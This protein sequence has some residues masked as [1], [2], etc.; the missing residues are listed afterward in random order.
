MTGFLKRDAALLRTNLKFYLVF[1]LGFAVLSVFTDFSASFISL[2]LVVFAASSIMGLFSYDDMNHW[3]GYAA[4]APNGRSAMVNARYLLSLL[5]ALGVFLIQLILGLFDRAN[6]PGYALFYGD[7][8]FLHAA[9]LYAGVFLLYTAILLPVSYR[10][11]GTRS[12]MVMIGV[13][14][15]LAA[16]IA[17]LG[18]LLRFDSVALA[19]PDFLPALVPA[20]GAAAL[21]LSWR[22]SLHIM[23]NKEL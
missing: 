20:A 18:T 16:L 5:I 23:A 13:I 19:L 6:T 1:V 3:Q 15:A 21:A 10:F 2:Y 4:A 8:Y 22:L 14:A 12:R 11:G 9:L 17:V 7:L